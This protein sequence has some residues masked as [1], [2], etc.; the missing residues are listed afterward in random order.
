MIPLL[1][2]GCSNPKSEHETFPPLS[3]PNDHR[4]VTYEGI[5]PLEN[6]SVEVQLS[7]LPAA[8]GLDSKFSLV[9]QSEEGTGRSIVGDYHTDYASNDIY[10]TLLASNMNDFT[11]MTFRT[12]DGDDLTLARAHKSG[13]PVRVY[14]LLKRLRLFTIEGYFSKID[15]ELEFFERNTRQSWIVIKHGKFNEI[16]A[17][18]EKSVKEKYEGIFVRA[19]AYAVAN[20]LKES[21]MEALVF[22]NIL[23]IGE[24]EN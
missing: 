5:L 19:L 7:L 6:D 20:P 24:P 21:E 18:Y 16:S 22:K 15:G 9:L 23:Q 14:K 2:V 13:A 11:G 10:V 12:S 8:V 17:A 3:L 1:F 4:W